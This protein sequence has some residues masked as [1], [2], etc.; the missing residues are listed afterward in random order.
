[1]KNKKLI[2]HKPIMPLT[3]MKY[4]NNTANELYRLS[5]SVKNHKY[6]NLI[7]VRDLQHCE[8]SIQIKKKQVVKVVLWIS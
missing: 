7:V 6:Y 4:L 3:I 2:S 5:I 8:P 1:M